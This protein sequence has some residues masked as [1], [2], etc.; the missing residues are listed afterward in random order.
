MA[1]KVF[2]REI[3]MLMT[4]NKNFWSYLTNQFANKIGPFEFLYYGIFY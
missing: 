3:I 4:Y 2:N 1:K